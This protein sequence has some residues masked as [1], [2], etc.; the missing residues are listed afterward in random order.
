M[1]DNKS[2]IIKRLIGIREESGLSSKDFAA[3]AGI[4]SGNY[5]SIENKKRPL[6]PRVMR[7][8]CCAFNINIVWLKTGQGEKYVPVVPAPAASAVESISMSREVFDQITRLTETV[9]SQQRTIEKLAELQKGVAEVVR[10]A[11]PKGAQG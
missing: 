5:S 9:L 8:I 2:E 1:T 3:R 6:G 11:A 10:A 4:D 7:D